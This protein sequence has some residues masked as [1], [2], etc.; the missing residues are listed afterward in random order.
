MEDF[1]DDQEEEMENPDP[2]QKGFTITDLVRWIS[3]LF[4]LSAY[5]VIFLKIVF[6]K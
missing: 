5:L 4:V 1:R 6:L 3:V 2:I